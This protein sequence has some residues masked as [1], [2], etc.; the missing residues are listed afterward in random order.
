M[1]QVAR[2]G[3]GKLCACL[4]QARGA[5]RQVKVVRQGGFDEFGQQRIVEQPP[6][7]R[8]VERKRRLLGFGPSRG[9]RNA[10]VGKRQIGPRARRRPQRQHQARGEPH[11]PELTSRNRHPVPPTFVLMCVSTLIQ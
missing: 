2:T 4:L 6:V 10:R 7:L 9:H 5:L 1:R 11:C 3:A 8:D